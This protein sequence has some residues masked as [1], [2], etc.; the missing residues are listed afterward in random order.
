MEIRAQG[1]DR[2][3]LRLNKEEIGHWNNAL[4]EVCNGFTVENFPAAIGIPRSSAVALLE[5]INSAAPTGVEAFSLDELLA[6]RN[7]LTTVLAELDSREYS[8]RMGFSVEESQEMRNSLD[9]ITSQFR[10]HKTA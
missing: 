7:A 6:L 4:N 10:L 3:T 2:L 1:G 9:S 8:T 5:K